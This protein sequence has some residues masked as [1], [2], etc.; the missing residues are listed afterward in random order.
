MTVL[1]YIQYL[2]E[3]SVQ[4]AHMSKSEKKEHK[5]TIQEKKYRE[6]PVYRSRW[7]GIIPFMLKF[8]KKSS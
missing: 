6:A 8:L 7:F 5:R 4:Y 3:K 1:E 2:T